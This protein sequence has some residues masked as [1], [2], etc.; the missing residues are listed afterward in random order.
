MDDEYAAKT[1]AL[2]RDLPERL[3]ERFL[4]ELGRLVIF[5]RIDRP[6]KV[7]PNDQTL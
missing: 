3:A 7:D 2:M 1:A 5:T 6:N 4:A